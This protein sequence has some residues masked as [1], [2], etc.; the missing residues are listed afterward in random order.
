MSLVRAG[1]RSGLRAMCAGLRQGQFSGARDWDSN[2]FGLLLLLADNY[3]HATDDTTTEAQ[4]TRRTHRDFLAER[5]DAVSIFAILACYRQQRRAASGPRSEPLVVRLLFVAAACGT[6]PSGIA[7]MSSGRAGGQSGL[8][9]K[10]NGNRT[11][12]YFCVSS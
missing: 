10:R 2:A 12:Q 4:S 1:A 9:A 7:A 5:S 6:G 11:N 3:N 8:T